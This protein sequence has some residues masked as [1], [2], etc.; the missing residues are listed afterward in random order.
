MC[1][2][3][4]A[5]GLVPTYASREQYLASFQTECSICTVIKWS[6]SRLQASCGRSMHFFT[7]PSCWQPDD[8]LFG[9]FQSR[10]RWR[11]SVRSFSRSLE[12]DL[13][14]KWLI[15]RL[16]CATRPNHNHATLWFIMSRR[17]IAWN[18]VDSIYCQFCRACPLQ[19]YNLINAQ[20][21][22]TIT[23]VSHLIVA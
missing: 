14:Q 1:S 4:S 22:P 21:N 18:C 9:D 19:R 15:S 6:S 8:L 23:V 11:R 2:V 3:D 13:Y 5:T 7:I 20:L 10:A 12:R 17:F 16:S